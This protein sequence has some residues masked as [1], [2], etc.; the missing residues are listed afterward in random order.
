MGTIMFIT[1]GL[2]IAEYQYFKEQSRRVLILQDEY[3]LYLQVFK[4]TYL[5]KKKNGLAD[6]HLDTCMNNETAQPRFNVVNRDMDYLKIAAQN[7]GK[8]QLWH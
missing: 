2:L 5:N 3:Q 4:E 1:T 6:R 8:E 7:F